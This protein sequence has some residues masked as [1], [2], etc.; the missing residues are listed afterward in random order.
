MACR[1]LAVPAVASP[2]RLTIV[3]RNAT[4]VKVDAAFIERRMAEHKR[5]QLEQEEELLRGIIEEVRSMDSTL[6]VRRARSR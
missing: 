4:P 5:R 6:E 1:T 3:T 2:S